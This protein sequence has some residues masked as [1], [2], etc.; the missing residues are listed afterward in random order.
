MSRMRPQK[1]IWDHRGDWWEKPD[2]REREHSA[3][4]CWWSKGQTEMM[5][6]DWRLW[7][8]HKETP[9]N[10]LPQG[11]RAETKPG[12]RM[13][14]LKHWTKQKP[15]DCWLEIGRSAQRMSLPINRMT[16]AFSFPFPHPLD[17]IGTDSEYRERAGENH[18]AGDCWE[19]QEDWE[20]T[21]LF[22]WLNWE[23]TLLLYPREEPNSLES[24]RLF[25]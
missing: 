4:E 13:G 18:H 14:G 8:P 20:A 25:L 3:W 2:T 22:L 19:A 10:V 9:E 11:T 6:K 15:D 1:P 12:W 21:G 5:P 17:G 23:F 24:T 7:F 16:W